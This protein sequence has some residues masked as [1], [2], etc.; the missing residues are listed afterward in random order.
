MFYGISF[1]FFKTGFV[2]GAIN[3]ADKIQKGARRVP[4]CLAVKVGWNHTKNYGGQ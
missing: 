4:A 3:T 2:K 1:E